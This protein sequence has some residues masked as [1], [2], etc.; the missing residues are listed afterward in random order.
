MSRLP[1]PDL[2]PQPITFEE[3]M[4][5]VPEKFELVSGYLFDPPHNHKWRERLLAILLTNEGLLRTVRLAPLARWQEALKQVY[6]ESAEATS[7]PT[8][9]NC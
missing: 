7:H 2:E 3:F 8:G 4:E 6:G 1:V 5:L 9:T